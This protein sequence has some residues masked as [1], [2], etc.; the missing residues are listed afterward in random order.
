MINRVVN[1]YRSLKKK[2]IYAFLLIFLFTV[3]AQ[4][5]IQV[6]IY[7]Q[8]SKSHVINLAGKQRMLSQ[9]IAKS[10]LLLYFSSEDEATVKGQLSSDLSTLE[11]THEDLKVGN[12]KKDIRPAFT[13]EIK[14]DYL[15]LDQFIK[16]I[17]RT[18]NCF[19]NDCLEQDANIKELT[20]LTRTYLFKMNALV[21]KS[22]KEIKTSIQ[23]L[24]TIEYSVFFIIACIMLFEFFVILLP[25]Q[26]SLIDHF[27]TQ[28]KE[29][30]EKEKVYHMA[31]VGEITSEV[32]HEINNFMTVIRV[33]SSIMNKKAHGDEVKSNETLADNMKYI[34][35]IERNVA[36]IVDLSQGM[37]KLTRADEISEFEVHPVL[38]DVKDVLSD[39]LDSVGVELVIESDSNLV[40]KNLKTKLTQVLFNVTK[41]AMHALKGQPE[42]RITIKSEVKG[43]DVIFSVSDTG[44][45]ISEEIAQKI[46]DPFFTTKLA[47]KGTGLG[48]SLSK[49]LANNM[50]GELE[51]VS[52]GQP[53]TFQLTIKRELVI[54]EDEVA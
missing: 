40:V 11:A 14:A 53:T 22:D 34:E 48:L 30:A 33:S 16:D 54:L 45:G 25:F 8:Q 13:P 5:F 31:E 42:K 44:P 47:G 20:E 1:V 24:S 15:E 4:V 12:D 21:D 39:K 27:K 41:N 18:S 51:L 49:R 37:L 52:L 29:E 36:N 7:E 26:K 9:R 43:N 35:K 2:Y 17:R 3:I 19:L 28:L 38:D 10:A 23:F 32:L 50:G 46:M 6:Y